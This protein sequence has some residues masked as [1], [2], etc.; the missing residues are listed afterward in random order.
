MKEQRGPVARIADTI[1]G[2]VRR[3]QR[4]RE[5]RVLLYDA[6]GHPRLVAAGSDAHATLVAT[7]ERLID[8]ATAGEPDAAGEAED[9]L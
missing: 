7:A 8:A 2:T 5:P 9:G 1:S 6:D 4:A 3:R